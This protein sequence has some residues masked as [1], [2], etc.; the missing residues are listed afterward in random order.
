[1]TIE[2][3]DAKRLAVLI[4]AGMSENL[5]IPGQ[6]EVAAESLADAGIASLHQVI[7]YINRRVSQSD[8]FQSAGV[9]QHGGWLEFPQLGV[10]MMVEIPDHSLIDAIRFQASLRQ[11][12]VDLWRWPRRAVTFLEGEVTSGR[13]QPQEVQLWMWSNTVESALRDL[14][15]RPNSPNWYQRSG[16]ITDEAIEYFKG[17]PQESIDPDEVFKFGGVA[18]PRRVGERIIRIFDVELY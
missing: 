13:I 2:T 9:N 1:M 15:E 12:K 6:V 14:G 4:S 5:V 3:D 18:V 17:H 11:E 16:Q 8:V 10:F 7:D